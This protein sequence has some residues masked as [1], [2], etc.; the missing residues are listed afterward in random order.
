MKVGRPKR[1]DPA[2][3]YT[4]AHQFYC[5]FRRL[6]EG[7]TRLIIDK[8]Q[9]EQLARQATKVNVQLDDE[10][11]AHARQVVEK[12]EFWLC[13]G[14]AKW[15]ESSF[16]PSVMVSHRSSPSRVALRRAQKRRALDRSGPLRTRSTME[17]I[18][19]TE[20]PPH[21]AATL[22]AVGKSS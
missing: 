7:R 13:S 16:L 5:H 18:R 1:V 3:L 4:F 19:G 2:S 11:K 12:G 14:W 20:R 10:Q 15:K 6:S 17:G 21:N 9:Y 22:S 8:N